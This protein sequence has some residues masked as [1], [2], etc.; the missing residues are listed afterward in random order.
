MAKR[1]APLLKYDILSEEEQEATGMK[2]R[3]LSSRRYY[4]KRYDKYVNLQAGMLS[5]GATGAKD[6]H[7]WGWWIHDRLC[8]TGVFEDGTRC[9]NWQ[10][11]KVLADILWSE[12][13]IKKPFRG[14][15]AV[16]WLP[17][18]FLFGGGKARENGMF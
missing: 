9:S 5:D 2:Y 17:A 10:A 13:S 7:S 1:K 18:T 15:R 11:S 3:L 12:W 6:I 4:S 14:I 16:L 8:N